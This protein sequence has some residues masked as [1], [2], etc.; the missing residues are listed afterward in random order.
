MIKV[1]KLA[2]QINMR[3]NITLIMHKNNYIKTFHL[4]T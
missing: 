1:A 3:N 4:S 2:F